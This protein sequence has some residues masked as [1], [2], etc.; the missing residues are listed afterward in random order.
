MYGASAAGRRIRPLLRADR[1]RMLREGTDAAK[2]TRYLGTVAE[3]RMGLRAND[4]QDRAA[5]D[6]IIKWWDRAMTDRRAAIV[7][8]VSLRAKRARGSRPSTGDVA[9]HF[10]SKGFPTPCNVTL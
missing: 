8:V 7:G 9:R 2:V 3:D 1:A 4:E 6:R 5:A 10:V